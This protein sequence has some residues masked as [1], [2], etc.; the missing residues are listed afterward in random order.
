MQNYNKWQISGIQ[1][2]GRVNLR[3]RKLWWRREGWVAYTAKRQRQHK[4]FC[5]VITRAFQLHLLSQGS[6]FFIYN[7]VHCMPV[8][9]RLK[10]QSV[11]VWVIR[12][13]EERAN[14]FGVSCLLS[15]LY[16]HASERHQHFWIGAQS[17]TPWSSGSFSSSSWTNSTLQKEIT[18]VNGF[19]RRRDL[20]N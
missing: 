4:V 13:V 11:W 10:C 16:A 14:S 1:R 12:G 19:N 17:T 15:T 3:R 8:S 6:Q 9:A 7:P 2:L 18:W 20:Y 5:H